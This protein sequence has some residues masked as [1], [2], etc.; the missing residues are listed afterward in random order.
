MTGHTD[1]L[2]GLYILVIFLIAAATM[3]TRRMPALLVLPLMGLAIVGGTALITHRI[4]LRTDIFGGVLGEGSVYLGKAIITAFFGGMLSYIMQKSGVA[5]SMVKQ[6]AELIGDNPIAVAMFS[7]TFIA[8]L[9]TSIGGLGAI[10]MVAMVFLPMLA[11]VGVPPVVAGAIMLIGVSIG[12]ALNPG[13]WVVLSTSLGASVNDVKQFA[14]TSLV[15]LYLTGTVFICVELFRAGAVRSLRPLI[16]T[17]VAALAVC[18]CLLWALARAGTGTGPA[19]L[20]LPVFAPEGA[21]YTQLGVPGTRLSLKN[22]SA[23]YVL[24]G[25]SSGELPLVAFNADGKFS[26]DEGFAKLLPADLSAYESLTLQAGSTVAVKLRVRLLPDGP[27]GTATATEPTGVE[28]AIPALTS[29]SFVLPLS[30]FPRVDL[31]KVTG[32]EVRAVLAAPAAPDAEPVPILLT[33]APPSFQLAKV[34]PLWKLVL[35]AV[36]GFI[37]LAILALV[38]ADIWS[39]LKRWRQQIVRIHWYS[40]LIPLVPLILILVYEVDIIPAFF[41]GFCYAILVT[42]RPGSMSMTIQC[43]I[44]GAATILPAG[45]LMIGLGILIIAIMGPTGWPDANGGAIWPVKAA[46]EPMLRSVVPNSPFKF[47]VFF[48]LLAPLA[49]YRGPLNTYGLGIGVAS[50]LLAA[51]LPKEAVVAM[52]MMVGQVQGVCDPT[53]TANVWLANELRVDVQSLLWRTLP[54]IWVMVFVG[55][56]VAA[57][58]IKW[59]PVAA[60][61][62]GVH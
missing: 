43:M 23:T 42:L 13:N 59:A 22:G 46:L 33:L 5:Q 1:L 62:Q 47:V 30:Q 15:L 37:G 7:M 17:M 29:K 36:F 18:G 28:R 6:A 3:F 31:K 45:L 60:T 39:R 27:E 32:L 12:G 26:T 19:G 25:N 40:Y 4:S 54:Y 55:L 52:L 51:G 35:R 41:F 38:L 16:I 61:V 34:V 8:L 57:F 48:G 11:T 58:M 14:M 21:P 20:T 44:Q 49:L 50:I 10:I 53:N 24:D 2:L 9:F 56:T